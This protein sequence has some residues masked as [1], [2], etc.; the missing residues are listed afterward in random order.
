MR[1]QASSEQ[2][3]SVPGFLARKQIGELLVFLLIK[4]G[5]KI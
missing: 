4:K 2:A 3:S 1:S 5:F